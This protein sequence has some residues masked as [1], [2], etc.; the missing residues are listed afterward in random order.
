MDTATTE[1]YYLPLLCLVCPA[2]RQVTGPAL[3]MVE[4]VKNHLSA[5]MYAKPGDAHGLRLAHETQGR[6]LSTLVRKSASWR[7]A[8][9]RTE[10]RGVHYRE[11]YPHRDDPN[12]LAQVKITDKNGQ[13]SMVR[14]PLPKK[15]RPDLTKPYSERYPLE[16]LGEESVRAHS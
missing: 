4:F 14:E 11:D 10:S 2:W 7:A 16:Y 8:L 1:E 12:W 9:F 3:T 6:V 13:M 15:Q 5:M